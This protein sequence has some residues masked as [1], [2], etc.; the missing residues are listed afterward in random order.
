MVTTPGT[1]TRA[2][3][4]RPLGLPRAVA[5]RADASGE[6]AELRRGTQWMAVA[7]VDDA[8]R[9]ATEWWREESIERTYYRVL[10][11]DGRVLTLFHDD[12]TASDW[13][14]QSY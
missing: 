5:V 7:E 14:E 2:D 10:L 11:V 9:I 1:Q 3:G 13:Y 4:L 6:P 12:A 8:W